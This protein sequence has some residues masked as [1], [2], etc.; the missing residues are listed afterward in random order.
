MVHGIQY[1]NFEIMLTRC[2]KGFPFANYQSIPA[3]SLWF[4]LRVCTADEDRKKSIKPLILE[5]QSLS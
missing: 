1:K 5:V 3:I 2:V 4:I